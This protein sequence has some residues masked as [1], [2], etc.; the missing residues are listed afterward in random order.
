ML[1]A[2]E[3]IDGAGKTHIARKLAP[4]LNDRGYDARYLNKSDISL[5]DDFA[6]SRLGLLREIIWP[7]RGEPAQDLLGTHFY[8]FLL[9]SWFSAVGQVLHRE[10]SSGDRVTVMDGSHYRVVAKAHCRA[11][12]ELT[13]LFRLFAQAAEPDLVVLLEIDPHVSWR[14]RTAFKET[15]IGRWDGYCGDPCEAYCAYQSTIQQLLLHMARERGWLVVPQDENTRDTD[16][17]DCIVHHVDNATYRGR[18]SP[19]RT[20]LQSKQRLLSR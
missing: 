5:G 3:G 13:Q 7:E 17:V 4:Y 1:V 15:E 20:S 16:I 6:D 14:R 2:I 12:I 18:G 11:R 19:T 8:L 10:Q 9:A